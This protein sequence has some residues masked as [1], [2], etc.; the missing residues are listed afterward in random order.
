V[1]HASI[2]RV[3]DL[4][5]GDVRAAQ[6]FSRHRSVATVLRYDDNRRDLAGELARRLAEDSATAEAA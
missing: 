3:L 6:K 2:T 5:G 1:R 4:S